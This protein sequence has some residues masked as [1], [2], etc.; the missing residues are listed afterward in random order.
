MLARAFQRLIDLPITVIILSI[1]HLCLSLRRGAADPSSLIVLICATVLF[2]AAAGGVT[3]A[4][5]ILIYLPVAIV[6]LTVTIFNRG[7]YRRD[8][9]TPG[10]IGAELLPSK[11]VDITDSRLYIINNFIAVIIKAIAL[12]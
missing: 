9:G 11:T 7:R 5:Q 8:T 6:I 4:A 10:T 12:L 3:G 2:A 1:A